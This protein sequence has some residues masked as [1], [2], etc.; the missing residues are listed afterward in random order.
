MSEA[1][2]S[3]SE[4]AGL[5]HVVDHYAA[6]QPRAPAVEDNNGVWSYMEL[7]DYSCKAAM[8]FC[9][10]GLAEKASAA[11]NWG[12][13]P[14]APRPL[15][16]LTVRS[17]EFFA[18]CLG[19]WRLG[20]PVVA[21]SLDMADKSVEQS[22]NAQVIH[23]LKPLALVSDDKGRKLL[24]D[25][26]EIPLIEMS[27]VMAALRDVGTMVSQRAAELWDAAE[28]SAPTSPQ[29]AMVYV[30]TGGTTKASKCVTVTHAMA[31]WEAKN[32]S[33]A[34][35]GHAGGSDKMLQ[36]SS[37]YWGAA[38][39]G[40]ISLGLSV[41]ACVCIGG[42]PLG[43]SGAG[44][45]LR[46]IAIDVETFGITVLGIVPS[47]L[48]GAWPG[49]PSAA[50]ACLRM[51]VA[52]ADKCP[53]DLAQ[54]WREHGIHVVDLL[55]ASEYW[56]AFYSDCS[57]WTD[58]GVQKHI[59]RK[60][61]A[62][63]VRFL[64]NPDASS[65]ND[66]T[67]REATPGEV[68]EMFLA[69]ATV[70]PGYV[71]P[72]GR[73]GLEY[74]GASRII[75]GKTYL[76]T[77][78]TMRVL[79]DGGFVYAGRADSLMKHAGKWV[80]AAALQ[81]AAFAVPGVTQAA[82][83]SGPDGID[84][85]VV[86]HSTVMDGGAGADGAQAGCSPSKKQCVRGESNG[87]ASAPFRVLAN[88][89]RALPGSRVHLCTSL[90]LNP[91]T[92]KVDRHALV[93]QLAAKIEERQRHVDSQRQVEQRAVSFYGAWG[94]LAVG[95]VCGPQVISSLV[96][97]VGSIM[98]GGVSPVTTLAHLCGACAA[99]LL[100]LPGLWAACA[101]LE[102]QLNPA[103]VPWRPP[104]DRL[105]AI[106]QR[107]HLTRQWS[108]WL[109]LLISALLPSS[110]LGVATAAAC[111]YISWARE[112][113]LALTIG[114]SSFGAFV[115]GRPFFESSDSVG[116]SLGLLS[117]VTAGASRHLPEV[118]SFLL[119]TPAV[120]YQ[121]IPKYLSDDF[122]WLV[123]R[124]EHRADEDSKGLLH[125]FV[126]KLRVPQRSDAEAWNSEL[127]AVDYDNK[128]DQVHLEGQHCSSPWDSVSVKI[129]L[130]WSLLE[131]DLLAPALKRG[132]R[133]V[134]VA[135][136]GD[137]RVCSAVSGSAGDHAKSNPLATLVDRIC[138]GAGG[139]DALH[140]M[141]SMQAIQLAEAV[142]QE[143]G[144]PVSVADVLRCTDVDELY[145][146]VMRAEAT[147]PAKNGTDREVKPHRR[148][149][150]CG[151]GRGACTVD[152][153]VGR[154]DSTRHLD[155]ASFQRAL[156]RLVARHASLRSRNWA[157]QAMFMP[158]YDAASLWQ[159]WCSSGQEWTGSRMGRLASASMFE[160]W[161]RSWILPAGD[162]ASKVNVL[163]PRVSDLVMEG[164]S[165][166]GMSDDEIAYWLGGHLYQQRKDLTQLF[167]VCI[168]PVFR[169]ARGA[170][171][172]D[173]AVKVAEGLPPADVRWYI[174]AVLDHGY[175]DGPAGLPIFAD[176]LRLYAEESGE[177]EERL[178]ADPP[179]ALQVLEK[180][181]VQSLKPLPEAEHP[182][183]DIFHDG[184]VDWGTR[185]GYQRFL[186]FD[187]NLMQVMRYASKDVLGCSIDVAWLTA[188][189]AA[190]LRLFPK[191]QRLDLFLIVT[192]RDKPAEETMIGYFSSRKMLPLEI[193]DAQTVAML[194]L[195][196]MIS[197]ARR[198]R[199]WHRP[200]P[201]EKCGTCIEVNIVSQ[202]A[203]G[204][205]YGFQEVRHPKRGPR[206]WN[207]SGTSPLQLRLDQAGRD[208]WDFRLQ[209]HDA[210]WG[211]YWS[212]YFA[213]A[214]GSAIVDM[215]CRPTGP[216]VPPL[217]G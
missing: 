64:V 139:S 184:L 103:G 78:D 76:R 114:I 100:A 77:R 18:L 196:D 157:E 198:Q 178:V 204:L 124:L 67:C 200:R 43:C 85:F 73:V 149:W 53:V 176:L 79:P 120:F 95:L 81:D 46:Q 16:L 207:R 170:A 153:M 201:F 80:D 89:R 162:P 182:N 209:S 190:F 29:S 82:V 75:D 195:S 129:Y 26:P 74:H 107:V 214:L 52:W 59:Y 111:S 14:P 21:M 98:S 84:A 104:R 126:E 128:W 189:A 5:H 133:S 212:T 25:H 166:D 164:Q 20:L 194:G 112:H 28:R 91:A 48:R 45:A 123:K 93:A 55:I 68:G 205:P 11:P 54:R 32:Y 211:P 142:R 134:K 192:C 105:A 161:P 146:T 118:L 172:T 141:D 2:S 154:Q 63:D 66:G 174:Y 27:E 173:D 152:W 101:Y 122:G 1:S 186:Q 197:T 90:P 125:R 41:G 215:A 58:A 69:G 56:L 23:D 4:W 109:P 116:V 203:D 15:A 217:P 147:T 33:T 148:I 130:H 92:A 94:R 136:N 113:D 42:C 181:L 60:L 44:D 71:C 22:R 37:L 86:L 156:D 183:D 117:A 87:F 36:G 185:A 102:D 151:L 97:G 137:G 39:F 115:A 208:A 106:L 216:V 210:T 179:D 143:F 155:V 159:L 34:L 180:R 132:E 35:G 19:A 6:R 10:H 17:R 127:V 175:C 144:K 206:D 49:G 61:P 31:L 83:V 8:L 177:S 167:A 168:I 150:L 165:W 47:Q 70:S 51:L 12:T 24:I 13:Q 145:E 57:V 131:T 188:I 213:Q 121:V 171:P 135:P 138:G 40:Q 108:R 72:D 88:V 193:G 169:D 140:G 199:N 163:V 62:L 30:Y 202:A 187:E 110:W 9:L 38:V 158:T 160:V 191:L 3:T 65:Q 7:R 119:A 50:P 96:R 99:R